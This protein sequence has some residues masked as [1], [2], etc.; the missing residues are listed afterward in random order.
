MEELRRYALLPDSTFQGQCGRLLY[1]LGS[2]TSSSAF[3]NP[4]GVVRSLIY[5]PCHPS[6][7]YRLLSPLILGGSAL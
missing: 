4:Y 5:S 7:M 3:A 6:R 2:V 1:S